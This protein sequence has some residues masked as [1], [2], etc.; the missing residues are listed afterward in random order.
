MKNNILNTI[1]SRNI[2]YCNV[3]EDTSSLCFKQSNLVFYYNEKY[4][5]TITLRDIKHLPFKYIKSAL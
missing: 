3:Q 2:T 5:M 4:I 1:I